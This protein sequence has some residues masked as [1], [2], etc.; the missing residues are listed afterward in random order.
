MRVYVIGNAKWYT[1]WL[2]DVTIVNKMEEA[3]LV[4]G[5]GGEDWQPSYYNERTGKYTSCNPK[6]DEFEWAAFKQAV[7]LD[8]P[9]LGVCRSAQG[10]SILAGGRLIQHQ[11]D[12]APLHPMQTFDSKTLMVT[13]SHH[14]AQYPYDMPESD[15]KLLGWTEN[16]S[17]YHLDGE[18]KEINL[19]PFKEAEVVYYPK[20]KA[21]AIQQHPEYH[22]QKDYPET[23]E[24]LLDLTNKL[25]TGTL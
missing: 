18:N 10:L 2:P 14:Q 25:I 22:Q 20:I 16:I 4:L 13:S 7:N 9:L 21:L 5:S 3:D 17:P 23:N 19:Q 6:R 12:N 1:N 8:K 15:F 24:W 11:A